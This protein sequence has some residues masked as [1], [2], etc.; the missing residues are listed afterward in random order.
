MVKVMSAA[1][2]DAGAQYPVAKNDPD[3]EMKPMID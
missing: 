1:L 2:E 3:T